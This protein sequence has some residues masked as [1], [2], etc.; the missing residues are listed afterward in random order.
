MRLSSSLCATARSAAASSIHTSSSNRCA[1]RS[2]GRCSVPSSYRSGIWP[3]SPAS[4]PD[5]LPSAIP[6][7]PW[8]L[9]AQFP[10]DRCAARGTAHAPGRCAPPAHPPCH[11][12]GG[13][14][15]ARRGSLRRIPAPRRARLLLGPSP[16]PRDTAP[17]VRPFDPPQRRGGGLPHQ[18]A[19]ASARQGVHSSCGVGPA[20]ALGLAAGPG[21][22][23]LV[24]VPDT[25]RGFLVHAN[26]RCRSGFLE[27]LIAT[28]C[29][30]GIR[31]RRPAQTLLESRPCAG[32]TSCGSPASTSSSTGA[33]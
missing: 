24:L 20:V 31:G 10:A 6:H 16:E 32:F 25:L 4:P 28:P 14:R 5:P 3:G 1:S 22:P 19:G 7:R 21:V 30:P 15:P 9:R 8:L 12:R 11:A 13:R 23:A 27:H 26:V 29:F 2:G 18:R 17:V 33:C